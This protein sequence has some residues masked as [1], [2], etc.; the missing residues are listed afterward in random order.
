[1]KPEIVLEWPLASHSHCRSDGVNTRTKLIETEQ[2]TD[3]LT[4]AA[5][6]LMAMCLVTFSHEAV[7]HGGACLLLGGHIRLLT[8]SVFR[9]DISS[10]WVDAGGPALNLI[11]GLCALIARKF[12]SLRFTRIRL[13]LILVTALSFFWE[14]GYLVQAMYKQNG[15]LYGFELSLLGRVTIAER[16]IFGALGV[17]LY[18]ATVRLTSRALL[19]VARAAAA[20]A[21]ARTAWLAATLG[22]T[23]AATLAGGWGDIR[24]AFLEIGLASVALLFI[25]K[26]VH[27]ISDAPST[28]AIPRNR[29]LVTTAVIVFAAF[30]V[31]LGRGVH[32]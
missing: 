15:D 27:Q 29:L 30:A 11:C 17:G 3:Q 4:V 32:W 26:E 31:T 10:E 2:K 8:S 13:F 19:T 12:I 22:A 7:G 6:G 21:I 20:R 16:L 23:L 14:G 5:L 25:P 28:V 24:D 1:M 18:A 9:C